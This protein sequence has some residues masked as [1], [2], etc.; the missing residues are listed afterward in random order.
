MFVA[1]ALVDSWLDV[2]VL[3]VALILIA[4]IALKYI[5]YLDED[6]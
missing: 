4:A 5:D 3:V 1:L 2:V 6:K